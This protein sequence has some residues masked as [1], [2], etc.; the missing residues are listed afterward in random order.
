[1]EVWRE[2]W[3]G[4]ESEW[5]VKGNPGSRSLAGVHTY[6][7]TDSAFTNYLVCLASN[8]PK[9]SRCEDEAQEPELRWMDG[10]S[11]SC[12][13]SSSPGSCSH[14]TSTELATRV[15]TLKLSLAPFHKTKTKAREFSCIKQNFFSICLPRSSNTQINTVNQPN[16]SKWDSNHYYSCSKFSPK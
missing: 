4:S 6:V 2:F 14:H 8:V 5:I 7:P 11:S 3:A 16:N 10:F 12:R 13:L 15:S 1:M 9:G